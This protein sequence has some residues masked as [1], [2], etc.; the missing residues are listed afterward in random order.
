M[1]ST[2]GSNNESPP[3]INESPPNINNN[4]DN[5]NERNTSTESVMDTNTESNNQPKTRV[6]KDYMFGYRHVKKIKD[7]ILD[8]SYTLQQQA[9]IVKLLFKDT[10]LEPVINESGIKIKTDME[11]VAIF[12]TNQTKNII[13]LASTTSNKNGK[14]NDDRRSFI[15]SNIIAI[16]RNASEYSRYPSLTKQVKSIGLPRSTG[17]RLLSQSYK[18]RNFLENNL[19]SDNREVLWSSV[20]KRSKYSKISDDL[21]KRVVNWL[22]DHPRIIQSPLAN[23]VLLI[24]NP[25][26][27]KQKIPV[28]KLLREISIRELHNDLISKTS[29]GLKEVYDDNDKVIISDTALRSLIP[30]N[31]KKM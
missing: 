27:P 20:K 22:T 23:D 12:N 2:N 19:T 30:P 18:K 29:S 8:K 7:I 26:N 4:N 28:P 25:E 10:D 14:L 6:R 16:S 5:D 24:K 31:I 17:L 13:Q 1:H 3:N 11:E 15:E 21:K 9:Y